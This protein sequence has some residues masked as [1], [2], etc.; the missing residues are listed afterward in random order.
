M[1]RTARILTALAVAAAGLTATGSASALEVGT[2]N[3][4]NGKGAAPGFAPVIGWQEAEVK[5]AP[6]V[7]QKLNRIPG[8]KT[9]WPAGK[10]PKPF[11]ANAVPISWRKAQFDLVDKGSTNTIGGQAGVTPSRWVNW[12]VLKNTNTQKQF[13]FVDTH[14]ISA[15]YTRHPD[16][17]P[18]WKTHLDVL[19]QVLG[20]LAA[21]Y[22]GQPTVVVGDFNR[23]AY[24]PLS[25]LTPIT[26]PGAGARVPY[27]QLYATT[28]LA[29][30]RAVR[31]GTYG[32]DH[33]AFKAKVNI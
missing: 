4:H 11:S 31:L 2:H 8:Y 6:N 23:P 1:R 30:Q 24:S 29:T 12:V 3:L 5:T 7:M 27:D 32:S 19:N 16:R 13:T 26:W 14:F 18:R 22:P 25:G 20:D 9:W 10:K 15:A 17:L 21:K 33:F 28:G